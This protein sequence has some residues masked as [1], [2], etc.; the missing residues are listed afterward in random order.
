ML[1]FGCACGCMKGIPPGDC[2]G[3]LVAATWH[4]SGA[5]SS[6]IAVGMPPRTAAMKLPISAGPRLDG[7]T[8][9]RAL[10][11]PVIGRLGSTRTNSYCFDR[12][13]MIGQLG[14]VPIV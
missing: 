6:K 8:A 11:L 9:K 12:S 7:C 10:K 14:F 13:S 5:G 4:Q 3:M 1:P 2:R